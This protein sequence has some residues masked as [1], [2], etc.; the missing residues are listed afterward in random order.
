MRRLPRPKQDVLIE[1][2]LALAKSI[3]TSSFRRLPNHP[4]QDILGAAHLG[5]TK[6]ARNFKPATGVPFECYARLRITGEIIDA[7]RKLHK[8][9]YVNEF[10]PDPVDDGQW[11]QKPVADDR[12]RQALIPMLKMLDEFEVSIL[13]LRFA[14]D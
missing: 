11:F 12:L 8:T 9:Q 2:H 7:H 5:L 1:A 10:P 6:A 4:F 3:A 14:R 13:K